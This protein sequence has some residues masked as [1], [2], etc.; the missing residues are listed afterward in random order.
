MAKG[1]SNLMRVEAGERA[2]LHDLRAAAERQAKG[3]ATWL[4][5]VVVMAYAKRSE[6]GGGME[7]YTT[8]HDIRTGAAMLDRAGGTVLAADIPAVA[9]YL[10]GR[11]PAAA[12][13]AH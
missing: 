12:P 10:A 6:G 2:L 3:G 11:A 13:K 9:R 5:G 7:G 1:R 8:I 4:G